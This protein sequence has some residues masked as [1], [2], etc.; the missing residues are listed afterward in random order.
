L[1]LEATRDIEDLFRIISVSEVIFELA[2][3]NPEMPSPHGPGVRQNSSFMLPAARDRCE[4][5]V[6]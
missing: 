6:Q 3:V 1:A 2:G 5:P 4:Q